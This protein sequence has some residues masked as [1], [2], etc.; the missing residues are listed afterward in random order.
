MIR[1]INRVSVSKSAKKMYLTCL[2]I[3]IHPVLILLII[4]I[5]SKQQPQLT[6]LTTHVSPRFD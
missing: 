6:D 3:V 1:K 2:I 4:L 5:N